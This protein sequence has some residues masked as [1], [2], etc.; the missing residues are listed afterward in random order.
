MGCNRVLERIAAATGNLKAAPTIFQTVKD[1][2]NAGG[3]QYILSRTNDARAL[4]REIFTIEGDLIPNEEDGTLTVKLHHL[5]NQMS[6]MAVREL[7]NFLN[8]TETI[9]PGTNLRMVYK[10]VSN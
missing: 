2:P 7:L 9:Y 6:N 4:L 1:V 8:D 5:T 3:E 10:M